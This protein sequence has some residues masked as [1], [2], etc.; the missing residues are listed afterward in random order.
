MFFFLK[1]YP[2]NYLKKW[3]E[4]EKICVLP[5]F[6]LILLKFIIVRNLLVILRVYALLYIKKRH[7]FNNF[8]K[9]INKKILISIQKDSM[10][11]KDD[12]KKV[13]I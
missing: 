3:S 13:N 6:L 7:V 12:R 1:N 5:S 9:T 4:V 2:K 11:I 10:L 8:L